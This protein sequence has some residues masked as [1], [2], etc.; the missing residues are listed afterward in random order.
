MAVSQTLNLYQGTQDA[1]NNTSKL[2][3]LWKSTQSGESHNNNTRTAKYWVS[4]NGGAEK[5][6]IARALHQ[7]GIVCRYERH[8][9]RCRNLYLE[10]IGNALLAGRTA[11]PVHGTYHVQQTFPAP[12]VP[13]LG[14]GQR[15]SVRTAKHV[16]ADLHAGSLR[17]HAP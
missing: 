6:G 1:V 9:R 14:D 16:G 11:H 3:I 12:E 7:G 13:L 10:Q 17:A 4:I 5:V 2:R 15:I 8:A